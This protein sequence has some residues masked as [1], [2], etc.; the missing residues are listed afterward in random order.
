VA[1]IDRIVA[2]DCYGVEPGQERVT[3]PEAERRFQMWKA[4]TSALILESMNDD[5][6]ENQNIE[7]WAREFSSSVLDTIVSLVRD[8]DEGILENLTEIIQS[9]IILDQKICRQSA[10]VGWLF[11]PSKSL[12]SFNPDSMAV[13][14]GAPSPQRGQR[15]VMV[16]APGL[17]KRGKS[18]GENF[19]IENLPLKMEVFCD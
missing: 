15:I 9:S 1:V 5:E 17:K 14:V 2:A 10:R 3:A 11:P 6:R 8:S 12:L 13:E 19:E 7:V 18:T 4:T 16:V